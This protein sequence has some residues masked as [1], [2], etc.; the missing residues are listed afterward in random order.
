[1]K[2]CS[3]CL[4]GKPDS[5]F[6]R[7]MRRGKLYLASFCKEC[8]QEYMKDHYHRNAE[9]YK[10]AKA[11][12]NAAMKAFLIVEKSRPCMD[13]GVQ[14]PHYVMDFDHRE[15]EIKAIEVSRLRTQGSWR[16]VKEEIAKCDLVCSNC[17]RER[18]HRRRTSP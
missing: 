14:Y 7:R 16:R 12:L 6:H 4:I 9:K 15:G 1:M 13:C 2:L 10:K 11:D 3:K 8:H 18:T 5:A 17:H